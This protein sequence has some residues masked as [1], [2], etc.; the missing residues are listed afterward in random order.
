MGTKRKAVKKAAKRTSR[1][2]KAG[3][4]G[5]GKQWEWKG[6]LPWK[7]KARSKADFEV[8]ALKLWMKEMEKWGKNVAAKLKELDARYP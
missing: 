3:W 6:P 4:K 7:T 5:G 2:S 8:A 1:K